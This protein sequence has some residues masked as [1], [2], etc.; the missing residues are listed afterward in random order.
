M[1]S[2]WLQLVLS[3]LKRFNKWN[4]VEGIKYLASQ[5]HYSLTLRSALM[6]AANKRQVTDHDGVTRE[7]IQLVQ[8]SEST[9]LVP[10]NGDTKKS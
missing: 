10:I 2:V 9:A 5:P 7:V 1:L 6:L 3:L 4:F 8:H